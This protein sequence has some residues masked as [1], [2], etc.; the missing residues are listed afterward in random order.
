MKNFVLLY[1]TINFL[2]S[3]NSEPD[4]ISN[5]FTSKL[6]NTPV[7]P[8][9]TDLLSQCNSLIATAVFPFAPDINKCH[10]IAQ[11]YAAADNTD[12]V[13]KIGKFALM[14]DEVAAQEKG[15]IPRHRSDNSDPQ[16]D[17]DLE[18]TSQNRETISKR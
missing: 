15:Y 9:L 14:P 11:Q 5:L 12:V 17:S 18:E 6:S 16:S 8:I 1:L 13:F 10:N 2:N 4:L 3:I 7:S